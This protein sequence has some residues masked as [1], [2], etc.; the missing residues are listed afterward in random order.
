MFDWD[1]N[2]NQKNIE[3]HGISFEIAIEIFNDKLM[4]ETDKE[5]NGEVRTVAIGKI[6]DIVITIVY[7]FRNEKHRIISARRASKIERVIYHGKK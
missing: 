1:I 2:K 4:H 3:K 7:T 5:V 6:G